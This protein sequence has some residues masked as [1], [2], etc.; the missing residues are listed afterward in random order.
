[1]IRFYQ[2]K[3]KKCH[4]PESHRGY[5][6][7]KPGYCSY[8]IAAEDLED[9]GIDPGS[10]PCE[11]CMLP[12][13]TIPHC[14]SIGTRTR[15][16]SLEGI[17]TTLVLWTHNNR[18]GQVP[19]LG[20]GEKKMFSEQQQKKGSRHQPDSNRRGHSPLDFESNALTTRP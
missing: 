8:T 17:N 9:P 14:A 6:R 20:N 5:R 18:R 13:T 10:Q 2:N 16:L 19:A 3:T 4:H 11:G 15:I 7:H 1:M 12:C